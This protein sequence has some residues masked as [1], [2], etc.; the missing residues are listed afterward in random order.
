MLESSA[1]AMQAHQAMESIVATRAFRGRLSPEGEI[2]WVVQSDG[3]EILLPTADR[4]STL[5][6]CSLV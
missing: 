6:T 3:G 2:E 4:R 1:L 5:T